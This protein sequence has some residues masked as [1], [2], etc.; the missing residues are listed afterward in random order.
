[1]KTIKCRIC[2]KVVGSKG[3]GLHLKTHDLKFD[4]YLEMYFDDFSDYQKCEICGKTCK[5]YKKFCSRKCTTKW[6][7]TLTGEN[8]LRYGATLSE[9]TKEKISQTQRERLK[10]PTNHPLYGTVVSDEVREKISKSQQ[11]YYKNN[12][13]YLKGKTYIEYFGKERAPNIIKKIFQNRPMNKLEELVANHLGNLGLDYYF[14]F[15]INEDGVCKS[16]DFKLKDSPY[17]IE[18]HGDYWHGGDGV[19]KHVFNVD[20]N[21]ENDE[22]K[23]MIAEKRGYEII[24]VWESEIKEDISI[25]DE[26]LSK[27]GII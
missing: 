26:R 21:I 16:Y 25:I 14:Q 15:F 19:D 11:E 13:P 4:E 18:V 10:D 5:R 27:C 7:K 12:E 24:V 6:R 20:E 22:L 8:A 1:M 17:I 3:L 2:D 9:E 23:R